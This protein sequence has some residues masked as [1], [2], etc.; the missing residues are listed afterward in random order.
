ME[1]HAERGST[2]HPAKNLP[3][4]CDRPWSY[5]SYELFHLILDPYG[6]CVCAGRTIQY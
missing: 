5:P 6:Y 2:T 3:A 1:A 4:S